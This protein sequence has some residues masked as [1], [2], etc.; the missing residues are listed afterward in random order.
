MRVGFG[1]EDLWVFKSDSVELLDAFDK[2]LQQFKYKKVIRGKEFVYAA[3][4]T[5]I[6]LVAHVDTV[7]HAPPV[8]IFHDQAAGVLWSPQGLGADDRAGVLGILEILRRGHKPHVLFTDGEE[9]GCTGAAEAISVL[10]DPGVLY[11]VELDRRNGGEAVFYNCD[12]A[13]FKEYVLSFGFREEHGTFT[14]IT[15][16]CPAWGVAGVNLSCGYYNA[17]DN[18]E[19]LKLSELWTTLEK[20]EKMLCSLPKKRFKYYSINRKAKRVESLPLSWE[21]FGD[22]Y[23]HVHNY[24]H[25]SD[26]RGLSYGVD[27]LLLCLPDDLVY[28]YGHTAEYWERWLEDHYKEVSTVAVDAIMAYIDTKVWGDSR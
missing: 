23:A 15:T 11:V 25:S 22:Q 24:K 18:A 7:H 19:Y 14:D 6:L 3:G 20:L 4:R 5:P 26:K 27:D 17:H 8:N 13:K 1:V 9:S 21:W 28:I 10:R 16:L 12:N 2:M